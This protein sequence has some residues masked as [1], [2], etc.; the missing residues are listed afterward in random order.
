MR[1]YSLKF[2]HL[3][4]QQGAANVGQQSRWENDTNTDFLKSSFI[5]I[6]TIPGPYFLIGMDHSRMK[7]IKQSPKGQP[8]EALSRKP[9]YTKIGTKLVGETGYINLTPEP[10]KKTKKSI[11][12][13]NRQIILNLASSAPL[14]LLIFPN[15]PN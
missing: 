10:S 7:T 9:E 2:K 6:S 1:L 15:V 8:F 12:S 5:Q 3:A 13:Q 14:D 11:W 4:A